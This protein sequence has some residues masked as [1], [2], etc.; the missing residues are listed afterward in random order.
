[1]FRNPALRTVAAEWLLLTTLLL[2]APMIAFVI[3]V[4]GA[5]ML[6]V[7]A[8]AT[9]GALALYRLDWAMYAVILLLPFTAIEGDPG[10]EVGRWQAEG[11]PI[12][13]IAARPS[14]ANTGIPVPQPTDTSRSA[15]DKEIAG[16]A[17]APERKGRKGRADT[18][19]GR[20][21]EGCATSA[22]N[23]ID[24]LSV[25]LE[26]AHTQPHLLAQLSADESPDAVG[27]P[28][29]R[30][31]GVDKQMHLRRRVSAQISA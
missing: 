6:P 22:F 2:G 13:S 23:G 8:V 1:M 26:R 20:V 17:R 21:S 24:A 9:V 3:L 19:P 29:G 30:H 4:Y 28:A 15:A 18:H 25:A 11:A 27:L 7:V 14:R 10:L 31:H 5:W 12:M 16:R